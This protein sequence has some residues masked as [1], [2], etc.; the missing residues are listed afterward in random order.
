M[1]NGWLTRDVEVLRAMSLLE[2]GG[3]A[4]AHRDGRGQSSWLC[5]DSGHAFGVSIDPA[6]GT[7]L[8]RKG[9]LAV[10]PQSMKDAL[11]RDVEL[12]RLTEKSFEMARLFGLRKA[13]EAKVVDH[14]VNLRLEQLARE[15]VDAAERAAKRE[16][17]PSKATDEAARFLM[18]GV[19]R[20]AQEMEDGA[21]A[22]R[23]A[24][25]ACGDYADKKYHFGW[26]WKDFGTGD[27]ALEKKTGAILN[28]LGAAE[29]ARRRIAYRRIG[30][31]GGEF[32]PV[33][34]LG[35]AWKTDERDNEEKKA[36][37]K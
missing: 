7:R 18:D 17:N 14:A 35:A 20:L 10:K 26:E 21:E 31:M 27:D 30:G 13:E 28:A 9:L 3:W 2:G 6:V 1:K 15:K 34:H 25:A 22:L 32:W 33:F 36:G 4:L 23:E 8:I 12:Y 19:L 24:V 37:A 5:N 29:D 16:A 11:P